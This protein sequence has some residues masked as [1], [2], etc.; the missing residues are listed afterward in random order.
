M[1]TKDWKKLGNI[2]DGEVAFINKKNSNS[3][4]IT[5]D[6]SYDAPNQ[7][8][9]VVLSSKTIRKDTKTLYRKTLNKSQALKFAKSYM[10]K[11]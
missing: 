11:H 4:H 6:S 3:I 10:R 9:V 5:D 8:D 1:A 7:Y 2:K